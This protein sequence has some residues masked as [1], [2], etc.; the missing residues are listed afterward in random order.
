MNFDGRPNDVVRDVVCL[1]NVD[2]HVA[3]RC[4]GATRAARMRGRRGTPTSSRRKSST[5]QNASEN[6]RTGVDGGNSRNAR[7]EVR[8]QFLLRFVS[9][10]SVSLRWTRCLRPLRRCL[11]PVSTPI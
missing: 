4:R 5:K 1:G 11:V 6:R 9:V 10:V 7:R 2:W 8:C 3:P